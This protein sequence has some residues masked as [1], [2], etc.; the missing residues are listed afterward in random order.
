MTTIRTTMQ[1]IWTSWRPNAALKEGLLSD[2]NDL[3]EF[4]LAN[5]L[6]IIGSGDPSRA[7]DQD[8][9]AL[10][11]DLFDLVRNEKDSKT[12]GRE[13]I[14]DL[15]NP[16]FGADVDAHRGRIQDQHARVRC[17]PFRQHHSLLVGVIPFGN[18]LSPWP[19][20]GIIPC[21]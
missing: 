16:G 13:H 3:P 5:A 10:V 21:E 17:E 1:A 7:H 20:Y 4:L 15:E 11:Q 8:A 18:G 14:D 12:A 6:G 2:I 19:G 9:V